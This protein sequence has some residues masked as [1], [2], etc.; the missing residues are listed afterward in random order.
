MAGCATL[1]KD[2]VALVEL[3]LGRLRHGCFRGAGHCG[4]TNAGGYQ[5]REQDDKTGGLVASN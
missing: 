1:Q 2:L 3:T 5:A 4:V